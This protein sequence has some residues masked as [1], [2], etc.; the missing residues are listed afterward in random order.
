MLDLIVRSADDVA[1][2]VARYLG[3]VAEFAVA[4]DPNAKTDGP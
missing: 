2:L 1:L 3:F 4:G